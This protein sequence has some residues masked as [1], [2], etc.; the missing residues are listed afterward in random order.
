M[1]PVLYKFNTAEAALKILESGQLWT[2]DP[3]DFNDPFEILP[4]F[5]ER[6]REVARDSRDE[7]G[8]INNGP[9]IGTISEDASRD[10][11]G[12]PGLIEECHELFYQRI[13][14]RIRVIC[15]SQNPNDILMWSHYGDSHKG[16]T[17][18]FDV[19]KG[20]FPRGRHAAGLPVLYVPKGERP[21][22]PEHAYYFD[23]LRQWQSAHLPDGEVMHNGLVFHSSHLDNEIYAAA[24]QILQ[25]KHECWKYESEIRFVFDLATA[26]R[27]G[28]L[29]VRFGSDCHKAIE[30]DLAPFGDEAI[31]EI[32][33]G[34]YC[35]PTHAQALFKMRRGGRFP[36]A[37]FYITSLNADQYEIDFASADELS[38]LNSQVLFRTSSGEADLDKNGHAI[39]FSSGQTHPGK[40]SMLWRYR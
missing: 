24:V 38:M 18:G 40:C 15:F 16:I 20:S 9:N 3:M 13:S 29:R 19:T 6:R 12:M 35:Q 1:S 28:L 32:R 26:N 7:F 4:G 30:R 34:C 23:L 39:F 31:Q 21:K 11:P 5:D 10:Y 36:D 2:T 22:L 27:G 25:H 33:V 8:R 37:K 17:I 14:E